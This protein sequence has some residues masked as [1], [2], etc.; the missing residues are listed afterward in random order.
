MT[1]V[2]VTDINLIHDL[3][4]PAVHDASDKTGERAEHA[5]GGV[6]QL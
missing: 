3:R 1:L 4:A 2:S 6:R 5:G